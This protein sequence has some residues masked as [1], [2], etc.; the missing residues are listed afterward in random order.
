M[1]YTRSPPA[2]TPDHYAM[3]RS[4]SPLTLQ[5][6]E[7]RSSSCQS[8]LKL[9]DPDISVLLQSHLDRS[10]MKQRLPDD[11]T[12]CR[13]QNSHSLQ[14]AFDCLPDCL[15]HVRIPFAS[16]ASEDNPCVANWPSGSF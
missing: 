16:T 12:K 14:H 3:E 9:G 1:F 11:F 10:K 6:K 13:G 4:S 5:M 8:A 2:P 7:G 15:R